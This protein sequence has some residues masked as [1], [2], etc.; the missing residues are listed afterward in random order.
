MVYKCNDQVCISTNHVHYDLYDFYESMSLRS[1]KFLVIS[2]TFIAYTI[3]G[4]SED[5]LYNKQR[6]RRRFLHGVVQ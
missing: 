1:K 5:C 3:D 6:R 2:Y 4:A